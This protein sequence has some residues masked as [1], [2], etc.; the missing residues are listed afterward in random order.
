MDPL[1]F[2]ILRHLSPNGEARFWASRRV[3]DPRIPVRDLAEKAG[4]S[5]TGVRARLRSLN[6][7]GLVRGTEVWPNPSLFGV[8]IVSAEIPVRGPQEVRRLFEELSL[9]DGVTF[10]RDLLDEDDRKVRVHYIAESAGPT[11]R[12]TALLRRL[13]PSGRLRDPL[14]YWLPPC[15]RKLSRLDWKILRAVR[16]RPDAPMKAIASDLHIS[17]K[18]AS[19]RSRQLIDSRA[20][21]WTPDRETEELPLALLT[22]KVND[23]A[24]R[25]GVARKLSELIPCWMPVAA[26]GLGTPPEEGRDVTAGLALIE[27]P[28][29]LERTLRRI[30]DVPGVTDVR[31]TF[32]LGSAAYPEWFD[33]RIA[34][35]VARPS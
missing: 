14:P 12:R 8:S 2:A 23:Q 30:L 33:R 34:E 17:V 16:M 11:A 25:A 35:E 6:K 26:D 21:W 28:A 5:E 7:R 32:A 22:V 3:V 20:C 13:S 31:R 10:A 4:I 15:T 18:T 24:A 9:V 29:V 1:D 27:S 19:R